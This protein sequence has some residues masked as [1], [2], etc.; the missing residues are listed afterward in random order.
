MN[1]KNSLIIVMTLLLNCFALQSTAY[2]DSGCTNIFI[3]DALM[4][5]PFV[6]LN[7]TSYLIT[8]QFI[9]PDLPIAPC[10]I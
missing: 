4:D 3:V 10:Q 5:I 7:G 8:R 9:I 2:A 1:K 6:I